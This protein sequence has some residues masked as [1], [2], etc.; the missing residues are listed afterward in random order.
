MKVA[1][2][3]STNTTT[4]ETHSSPTSTSYQNDFDRMLYKQHNSPSLSLR[5]N[6]SLNNRYHYTSNPSSFYNS[7]P[8]TIKPLQNLNPPHILY[9]PMLAQGGFFAPYPPSYINQ[10]TS[11]RK[12]SE[13]VYDKI[14]ENPLSKMNHQIPQIFPSSQTPVIMRMNNEDFVSGIP[15]QPFISPRGIPHPRGMNMTH[16]GYMPM[17]N[18]MVGTIH[19]RIIDWESKNDT[20]GK[21]GD[22]KGNRYKNEFM[23]TYNGRSN[24]DLFV[25]AITPAIGVDNKDYTIK[26]FFKGFTKSSLFG[27]K[28]TY[29]MIKELKNI[30]Y[31]LTLSSMEISINKKG[32]IKES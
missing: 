9:S 15:V 23:N 1:S 6:L 4:Q 12:F 10:G 2:S 8:I 30:I 11:Q 31:S 13:N 20:E 16:G 22:E 32:S 24:L 17:G 18:P 7:P 19:K 14:K 5:S 3:Q 27:I 26:E 25:N 28:I 21:K 29:Y